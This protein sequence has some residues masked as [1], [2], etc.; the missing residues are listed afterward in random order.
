MYEMIRTKFKEKV[1]KKGSPKSIITLK[2]FD[3]VMTYK[4]VFRRQV[5]K[6]V[7]LESL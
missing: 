2:S 5:L 7:N 3:E 4:L 6:N 1:F